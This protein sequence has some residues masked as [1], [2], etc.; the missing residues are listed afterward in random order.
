MTTPEVK[1]RPA[2]TVDLDGITAIDEK[3]SG[4]Y[5][6][7][8]MEGLAGY[9]LRRNPEGCLVAEADGRVVGYMMGLVRTGEFGFNE[10]TAWIEVLGVDPDFRGQAVGR[11]LA[12]GLIE[13]FR[14]K[15]AV[16]VRTLVDEK[17]Q[18]IAGF[19]AALGFEPAPLRPLVKKLQ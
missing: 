17:A 7:G 5:R 19:F 9:Y 10:P 12:E 15:N 13:H 1:I 4:S 3:L 18:E 14:E 2:D 6:A 8:L 16:C 11:K